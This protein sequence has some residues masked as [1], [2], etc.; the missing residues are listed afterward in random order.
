MTFHRQSYFLHKHGRTQCPLRVCAPRKILRSR[1][2]LED[3]GAGS[4]NASTRRGSKPPPYVEGNGTTS[5]PLCTGVPETS[6]VEFWGFAENAVVKPQGVF[7]RR[8]ND[9]NN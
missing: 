5:P 6:A 2:S 8:A 7:E 4:T 9:I 1:C 3:D